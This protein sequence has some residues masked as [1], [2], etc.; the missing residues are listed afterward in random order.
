MPTTMLHKRK[1][2]SNSQ[3]PTVAQVP[4]LYVGPETTL[5]TVFSVST[6]TTVSKSANISRIAKVD[7]TEFVQGLFSRHFPRI[8]PEFAVN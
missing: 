4:C 7:W 3:S 1:L 5:R 6:H 2:F 8:S